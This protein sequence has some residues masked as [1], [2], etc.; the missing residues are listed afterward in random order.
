M[1]I[2][3]LLAWKVYLASQKFSLNKNS[4]HTPNSDSGMNFWVMTVVSI[5][6]TDNLIHLIDLFG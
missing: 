1:V 2:C 5:S 6:T 3:F 4:F